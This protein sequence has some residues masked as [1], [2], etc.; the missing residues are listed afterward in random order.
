MGEEEGYQMVQVSEVRDRRARSSAKSRWQNSQLK[1]GLPGRAI[2]SQLS[3]P[4]SEE[5]PDG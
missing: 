1:A 3:S 4:H 5:K 2:N